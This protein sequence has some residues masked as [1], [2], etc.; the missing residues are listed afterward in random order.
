MID[1]LSASNFDL[2]DVKDL[3]KEQIG[4]VSYVNLFKGAESQE[5]I[6]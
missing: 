5:R 4:P 6:T 1:S 2:Q 3:F